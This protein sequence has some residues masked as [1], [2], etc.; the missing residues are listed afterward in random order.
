[1]TR[2]NPLALVLITA[3][4]CTLVACKSEMIASGPNEP[5]PQPLLHP[6]E[7]GQRVTVVIAL[8]SLIPGGVVGHAGL[9]VGDEYWDFGP[10]RTDRLQRLRSIH[11]P[12]GPWWDD[13]DQQW[14]VNRD[15]E[16][17]LEDMPEQVHP[18]GSLIAV[19]QVQVTDKQAEAIREFWHDTYARMQEGEDIYALAGRQCA[20]MVAWSLQA[21]MH[22]PREMTD[23]L[24]SDLKMMSPTKLYETLQDSLVHTAGPNAGRPADVTLWQLDQDG[25]SPW[26]RGGIHGKLALPELPRI[27][28]AY[29]RF[30]F[31]PAAIKH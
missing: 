30:K 17:V 22:D 6:V 24:P 21:G 3:L 13:P 25:F 18:I 4:A 5:W 2:Y 31:L 19:V 1:M 14:V 16:E 26:H 8:S 20:N 7:E 29:E 27:R 15:L 28:L 10:M 23:R 12:A 9:A 11:S